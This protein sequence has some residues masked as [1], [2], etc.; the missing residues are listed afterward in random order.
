MSVIEINAEGMDR[1]LKEMKGALDAIG[2]KKA[3]KIIANAIN[4]SLS[5]GRKEAA[6]QARRAYTAPIKKL[7]DNIKVQR[8]RGSNLAGLIDLTGSK[9]VSMI[10]FK[11]QPNEPAT[12]PVQGVT[13]Q[14]KRKGLRKPRVSERGGSKSFVMKK[15]QGG[16]GV[17]VN[18][19]LKKKIYGPGKRKA[20]IVKKRDYYLEM[21]FGPS[22]IQYLQRRDAQAHVRE[23]VEEAFSPRLQTEID[24]ALAALGS[25]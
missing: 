12:H 6:R 20:R 8:A 21:L 9:G 16:F 10:H 15:A 22:P 1:A 23:K 19:G 3:N 4:Q 25:R 18:H 17:F 14:L 24:K 7:F 13:A 5:A 2:G 11:A